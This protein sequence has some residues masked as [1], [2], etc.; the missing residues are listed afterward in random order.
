VQPLWRKLLFGLMVVALA[1]PLTAMTA[2]AASVDRMSVSITAPKAGD[3]ITGFYNVGFIISPKILGTPMRREDTPYRAYSLSYAQGADV[4]DDGAF[5][6]W[7]IDGGTTSFQ[8]GKAV[9]LRDNRNAYVQPGVGSIRPPR[10]G[11][12]PWDTTLVP[13]GPVTLRIRGFGYDGSFKDDYVTA[14]VEN[15]G[16]SPDYVSMSAPKNGD[17]VTGWVPIVYTAMPQWQGIQRG[18]LNTRYTNYLPSC[19]DTD[20]NF[21]KFEYASGTAPTD[22]DMIL[23]SYNSNSNVTRLREL[24]PRD[25][26]I[27]IGVAGCDSMFVNNG[28]WQWDSTVVP[29]GPATLRVTVVDTRGSYRTF[30]RVVNV[31]NKGKGVQYFGIDKA[32]IT[33][34]ISG[35]GWGLPG[36]ATVPQKGLPRWTYELPIAYYA[37]DVA[38]G[39]ATKDPTSANWT[40]YWVNDNLTTD[41]VRTV[42]GWTIGGVT[43]VPDWSNPGTGRSGGLCR[44]DTTALANGTYTVQLRLQLTNGTVQRDW[45]VVEVKN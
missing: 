8:P 42:D 18:V 1:L 44:L 14:V 45:A 19:L 35:E 25:G 37:C 41:E 39:D 24:E 15:K 30:D 43:R 31:D 6:V 10:A 21:A 34:P 20:L 16:V 9:G 32:A 38:A 2:G 7:R 22:S 26:K 40:M 3:K 36:Y 13:D 28:G 11:G 4:R 12:H 29:D 33:G 23:W 27:A 17:T 5:S